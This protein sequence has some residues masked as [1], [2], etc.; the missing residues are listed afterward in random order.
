MACASRA[1]VGQA[2]DISAGT[3]PR[4]YVSS[5]RSLTTVTL[6]VTA[7]VRI[8]RRPRYSSQ[9][10]GLD[11]SWSRV[12]PVAPRT[13]SDDGF[14][15]AYRSD[16]SAAVT[17]I[18]H[19]VVEPADVVVVFGMTRRTAS[20]GNVASTPSMVHGARRPKIVSGFVGDARQPYRIRTRMRVPVA[21]DPSVVPR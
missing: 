6:G 5:G 7:E 8:R 18:R 10:L 14:A 19:V 11:Q 13:T 12:V 2:D 15:P 20:A 9:A 4:R 16:P 1:A 21:I 3:T 17:L